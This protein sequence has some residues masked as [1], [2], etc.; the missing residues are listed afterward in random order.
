MDAAIA[1]KFQRTFGVAVEPIKGRVVIDENETKGKILQHEQ[2]KTGT[3]LMYGGQGKIL[4][5][6]HLIT[7]K[8]P[9]RTNDEHTANDG[10]LSTTNG[11]LAQPLLEYMNG[12]VTGDD[13]QQLQKQ[14]KRKKRLLKALQQRGSQWTDHTGTVPCNISQLPRSREPYRNSMRPT[15]RAL[16][17]PVANIL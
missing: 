12:E 9:P 6:N 10:T 5:I 16:H 8:I 13:K 7:N 3:E 17:H 2:F 14:N 4:G 11:G 1:Q 15:G